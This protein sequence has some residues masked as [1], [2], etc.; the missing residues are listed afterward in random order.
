MDEFLIN[1]INQ[2]DLQIEKMSRRIAYLYQELD[3]A[4][5]IKKG[6]HEEI[7]ELQKTNDELNRKTYKLKDKIYML[8][9]R[10]HRW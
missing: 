2:K 4:E 6:L 10:Y 7:C 5:K 1:E 8:T 9:Y 3:E